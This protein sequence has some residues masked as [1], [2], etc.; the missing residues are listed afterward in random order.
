LDITE[1]GHAVTQVDV[2]VRASKGLTIEIGDL[3]ENVPHVFFNVANVSH[4]RVG[5]HWSH[6]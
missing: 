6:L 5:G 3:P 2:H 1:V 4:R